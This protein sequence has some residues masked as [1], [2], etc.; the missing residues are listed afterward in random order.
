MKWFYFYTCAII[1]EVLIGRG[2]YHWD[3]QSTHQPNFALKAVVS[4]LQWIVLSIRHIKAKSLKW[5]HMINDRC[6][7]LHE[8]VL[9]P[10]IQ[11]SKEP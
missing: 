4:F 9:A 11:V 8:L 10:L 7:S 2:G 6:T 3:E 1:Q 5:C